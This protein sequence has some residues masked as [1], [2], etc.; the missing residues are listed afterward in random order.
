MSTWQSP[1]TIHTLSVSLI[2]YRWRIVN[3]GIGLDQVLITNLQGN[4]LEDSSH[5]PC[6]IVRAGIVS[7]FHDLE[8]EEYRVAIMMKTV[9]EEDI[10]D[11]RILR[12]LDHGSQVCP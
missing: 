4:I 10:R 9:A 6:K 7:T 1:W 2:L 8:I 5:C 12:S 11:Q 3:N